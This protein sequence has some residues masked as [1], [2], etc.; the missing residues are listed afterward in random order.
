MPI[1]SQPRL[2]TWLQN[3]NQFT[4]PFPISQ[5]HSTHQPNHSPQSNTLSFSSRFNSTLNLQSSGVHAASSTWLQTSVNTSTA[6]AV[7]CSVATSE[8]PSVSLISYNNYIQPLLLRHS[9]CVLYQ[10]PWYHSLVYIHLLHQLPQH[11]VLTSSSFLTST[12]LT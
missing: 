9:S 8:E 4:S 12:L 2:L 6:S 1:S 11:I 10:R 7:R 3:R 5:L